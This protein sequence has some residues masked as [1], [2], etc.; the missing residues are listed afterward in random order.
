M[1]SAPAR[2]ACATPVAGGRDDDRART[3]RMLRDTVLLP[4][5]HV[6]R[7][8]RARRRS[9]PPRS[10]SA[11]PRSACPGRP[12]HDAARSA[13]TRPHGP[14]RAL[15]AP[16][17]RRLARAARPSSNV[18][19]VRSAEARSRRPRKARPLPRAPTGGPPRRR[20]APR[21]PRA[22]RLRPA[23]AGDAVRERSL[24]EREYVEPFVA[25]PERVGVLE[26]KV[27]EAV[28]RTQPRTRACPRPPIAR[29]SRCRRGRRRSPPRRP[30]DAA[31]S[32]TSR[33]RPGFA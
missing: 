21:S 3:Y 14:G 1:P 29:R 32:T 25:G 27:N 4:E 7:P 31:V 9:P 12:R 28:P 13:P 17:S 22:T 20:R 5:Q 15:G 26:R 33:D 30:R 2:N 18:D 8:P 19:D 24:A 11:A 23:E 6:A 10:G 16:P